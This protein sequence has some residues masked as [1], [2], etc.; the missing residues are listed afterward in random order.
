MNTTKQLSTLAALLALVAT[1]C[2]N[3]IVD[4][5]VRVVRDVC[6][7]SPDPMQDVTHVRIRILSED[8]KKLS[9]AIA[10]QSA[11]KGK[12]EQIPAGLAVRVEVSAFKGDPSEGKLVSFGSSPLFKVPD[13]VPE[14]KAPVNATVFLRQVERFSPVVSLED[15]AS[16]CTELSVARAGHSATLLDDGRV[17]FAGGFEGTANAT[18]TWTYKDSVEIFNPR[19][20]A[21]TTDT[22]PMQTVNPVKA[23][24]RAFHTA[25]RLPSGQ[26]L[27]AGGESNFPNAQTGARSMGTVNSAILFDATVDEGKG[28]WIFGLR[29]NSNRARHTATL[30]SSGRVL[31]VG[32]V[33]WSKSPPA[34]VDTIEWM[35]PEDN[36]LKKPTAQVTFKRAGHAALAMGNGSLVA[37]VGGHDGA[38]AYDT[39]AVGFFQ[40]KAE[41]S[42]FLLAQQ[43]LEL[44]PGRSGT[45]VAPAGNGQFL[46]LG[47]F[48]STDVVN[49]TNPYSGSD[50]YT[51]RSG[52]LARADGPLLELPRGYICSVTLKDGRVLAIG[53][54]G[55]AGADEAQES[56]GLSTLITETGG[57]YVSAKGDPL[58]SPRYFHSCTVLAD[59]A[60]LV[61]GGVEEKGGVFNTLKSLEIYTPRPVE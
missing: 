16:K 36:R 45:S 41:S 29:L 18:T 8:G 23:T 9:E 61:A 12:L 7:K 15:P 19:T 4:I 25:T 2:G 43:A 38:K 49:P 6:G 55:R 32:G 40:Y 3:K 44:K 21:I 58:A 50:V 42:Q 35:D 28:N 37:V 46:A 52:N 57:D 5:Q 20:G 13:T 48:Q 33:D 17:L 59:G 11:G 10:G 39:S 24:T 51:V 27:I 60:V 54:K 31:L 34:V 47:G 30:H 53:G 1:A 26:V 56:L 14:N 22:P